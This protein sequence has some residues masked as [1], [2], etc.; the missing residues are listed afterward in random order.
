MEGG[1][2]RRQEQVALRHI[3]PPSS[4]NTAA[5]VAAATA[6]L[7]LRKPLLSFKKLVQDCYILLLAG[8]P[9]KPNQT[10]VTVNLLP[11]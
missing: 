6:A 10:V 5:A 7:R 4:S 9:L 11:F 2:G 1:G 3:F 8:P